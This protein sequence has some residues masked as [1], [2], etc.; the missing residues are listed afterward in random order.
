MKVNC[1]QLEGILERQDAA[2]M[3]ALEEHAQGCEVCALQ[4]RLE[5]EISA[6]A[7]ALRKEWDSPGLWPRIERAIELEEHKSRVLLFQHSVMTQWRLAA[8]A[9]VLMV[10]TAAGWFALRQGEQSLTSGRVPTQITIDEKQ[11]LLNEQALEEVEKAE[12][13]YMRSIDRLVER[14]APKL[15][16]AD[17]SLLLNY[18]EKLLVLDAAIAE[19]RA[20]SET[21]KFN[22]HLRKE[23]LSMYQAKQQTL[24]QVIGEEV[25]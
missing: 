22:A 6:A 1:E 11:R 7:P 8:A 10:V 19:I 9:V 5:R 20:Q 13:A 21:N 14:A 12:A 24:E 23:L 18:K 3:A 25:R 4:L 16:Q 15:Q 2:E 17:S